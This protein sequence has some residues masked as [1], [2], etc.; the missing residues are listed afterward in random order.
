MLGKI[1]TGIITVLGGA[2]LNHFAKKVG[3]TVDKNYN[4][5]KQ[6]NKKENK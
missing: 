6:K 5:Y 2:I 3:N 4:E 1:V